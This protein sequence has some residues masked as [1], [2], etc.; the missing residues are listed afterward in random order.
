MVTRVDK[1]L[2]GLGTDVTN[3]ANVHA[4]E[5]RIVFGHGDTNPTAN[6]HVVGDVLATT[7]FIVP[8]DGDIGS[9]G[10]T[11]AIQISSGG[12][13]TFKDDIKIKDGGTI[14]S[15]SDPDAI[16]IS[17]GGVVTM[18]QIPVFSAGINVSGGSIA[19]TLSTAAQ[20]NITSLGTLTALTVDDVAINGKVITMTGDTSDTFTI[21]A[22]AAGATTLAT[23]DAA[24]TGGNLTLDADGKIILDGDGTGAFVEFHDSGTVYGSIS[25]DSNNMRIRSAI[26]SGDV[27]IQ[28]LDSG[29]SL[30]NSAKFDMSDSGALLL[31]NNIKMASDG[32]ILKMGQH[33]DV[34]LT[35]VADSGLTL[36]NTTTGDNSPVVL[37][38]KSE[39]NIVEAD[40]VIASIELAAGDSSGT[41]AATVA[42]GIHA[43]AE[44]T[45][46]SSANPTKLVFTTGVSETA[47]SSATAK[48]TLS[49]AGL[50]TIADDF[51]LKDGGTIGVA[52]TNDAMTISSAGIVTF[53]DDILIKDGGTI[54]VAS[55]VD[56]MTI[57]SAGIVTFK[58]DIILKDAA[59]IGVASSTSAISIASTGIVTFID[60]IIIKDGG[61]IGS[62]SDTNAIT[63][64][65]GGVVTMDQI[66]VFS[67]GINVS[68]GTIAGTLATAA[69]TN[70]TSVGA[71]DG[72]SITSNFGAINTGSSDI[73]TSGTVTGGTLAGT[74][75]TA[76]QG[77]ITSL[78]TLTTLTVDNII[79]NGTN[80]GHTSDTDAISIGSDGDVTLTQ[81]LE[82]QHDGATISFGGNDEI[83]LTHIHDT[84]L[85]LTDTGG[86]PTLQLHDANEAISS[87]GSKL[88]LT[89]NGVAFS[90]P[91]ADGSADQ[92]LTTNGS[93]TLSF[94]AAASG[95]A[96]PSVNLA[97]NID[98]GNLTDATS[99]AFGQGI[100]QI[101]DLLDMP[102][103]TTLAT[104]DLGAL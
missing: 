67:A 64:S 2:G 33:N 27:F 72:G 16:T 46:T 48:M 57:S 98:L 77:N 85:K 50:L 93:G 102:F 24:G 81:D 34:T 23:T 58:D 100:A 19:G 103:E 84:G 91:T 28:G 99:D 31:F 92:V 42:A 87:D 53:K 101:N 6:V 97:S 61:T 9:A 8:N 90:L 95:G 55:T 70:I 88:I 20:G 22:G 26:N 47:A 82:L 96:D 94:A 1:F 79:V 59:T 32:A 104:L 56:A 3:V 44:N 17:S 12:I 37:Q 60:D 80:I 83:V 15:A 25:Q 35:H 14:G 5:N 49:S 40:E 62:A 18:N 29:G 21:T 51:M 10:A 43:I 78:G 4:T 7:G 71:L 63:I 11:D 74:L 68:G 86:S 76:A 36:T 38:L 75:S 54:G 45:F 39:E 66:P 69:Q 73:T 13:V 89:S 30:V 65:S 52:S 41:D